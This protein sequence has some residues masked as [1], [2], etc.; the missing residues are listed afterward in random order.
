MKNYLQK[1]TSVSIPAPAAVNSGDIVVAGVLAGV[2]GHDAALGDPVEVH[3]VGC[4]EL[5]KVSAQAWTVGAAVYVTPASGLCT[6][7]P[8][9]GA[10]FI[11][12]AIEAAANP[13]GTGKV[14]LNGAAPAEPEA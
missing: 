10:I 4:Y 9:A 8:A 11:G 1:G 13:S 7:S 12:V 2:A 5:R 6:V 14:R 3:L